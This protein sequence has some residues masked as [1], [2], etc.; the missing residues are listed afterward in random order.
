M[1][2]LSDH[3]ACAPPEPRGALHVLVVEDHADCAF[4]IG[5]LLTRLG[6]EVCYAA[7]GLSALAEALTRPPDVVLLDIGLPD[8]DGYEVAARLRASAGPKP[9]LIIALSGYACD[10]ESRGAAGI[11]LYLTKPVESDE[12]GRVLRYFS[13]V[14]KGVLIPSGP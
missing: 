7:D 8:L 11:D 13:R 12:L 6:H 14:S 10:E 2:T 4:A 1:V 3:Y 5:Q 9:L